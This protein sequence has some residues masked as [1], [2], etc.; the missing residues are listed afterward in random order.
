M[1]Q[2]RVFGFLGKHAEDKESE[3]SR[4]LRLGTVGHVLLARLGQEKKKTI[5]PMRRAE[6][7]EKL[8]VGHV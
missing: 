4:A 6:G 8:G 2:C 5:G 1:K 7:K 3:V